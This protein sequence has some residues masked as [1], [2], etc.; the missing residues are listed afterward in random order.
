MSNLKGNKEDNRIDAPY[1]NQFYRIADM[2]ATPCADKR[3]DAL[4]TMSEA[5]GF[6]IAEI[7]L[8]VEHW[9]TTQSKFPVMAD[10]YAFTGKKIKKECECNF[11]GI[12]I[13]EYDNYSIDEHLA[14]LIFLNECLD[15]YNS[16]E[17]LCCFLY[18]E[19]TDNDSEVR[20]I[21]NL[22]SDG[23]YSNISTEFLK[24]E[25]K[26]VNDRLQNKGRK[27]RPYYQMPNRTEKVE[28]YKKNVERFD[29][30]VKGFPN[31][32]GCQD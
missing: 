27:T 21:K 6:K 29:S 28:R 9:I 5:R 32:R 12:V 31:E 24:S 16:S 18:R 17:K 11:D 7:I 30:C 15:R 2:L 8:F 22:I 13:A 10:I 4:S 1:H 26:L 20:H 14:R 19:Y 3:V 25:L 23:Q